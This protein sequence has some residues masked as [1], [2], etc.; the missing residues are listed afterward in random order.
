MFVELH[1]MCLACG[2]IMHEVL[3]C[4]EAYDAAK[5]NEDSETSITSQVG[6]VWCKGEHEF[7]V[8]NSSSGVLVEASEQARVEW[9]GDP[10]MGHSGYEEELAWAIESDPK[11]PYRIF[12]EQVHS[13]AGLLDVDMPENIE[14][15]LHVMLHG[16]LVAAVEGYLANTFVGLVTA[17]DSLTR[18]MYETVPELR[19]KKF[20][21][22]EV[23]EQENP[24]KLAI[25]SYLS[26]L[27]FHNLSKVGLMFKSVL[28]YEFLNVEWLYR[29]IEVRHDC[30]HRAGFTKKGQKVSVNRISIDDLRSQVVELVE[31]VEAHAKLVREGKLL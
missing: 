8:K 3:D 10:Y 18:K 4:P 6:C 14:F 27:V 19:N 29:A 2:G 30:V 26:D 11:E 9:L 22:R 16:H 28:G 20:D 5:T 25:A 31:S 21:W 13:V 1:F 15:S 17:S 23:V 7:I 12:S 24:A